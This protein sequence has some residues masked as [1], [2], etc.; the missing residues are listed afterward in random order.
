MISG[1]SMR[2]ELC[3]ILLRWRPDMP[4]EQ[5]V[6]ARGGREINDEEG[7]REGNSKVPISNEAA[8]LLEIEI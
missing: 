5:R 1:A 8:R 4:G 7:A 2:K 3:R 6:A